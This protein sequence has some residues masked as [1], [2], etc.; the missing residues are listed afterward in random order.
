MAENTFIRPEVHLR[1][2]MIAGL[3]KLELIP[4]ANF[5]EGRII[6]SYYRNGLRLFQNGVCSLFLSS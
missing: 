2:E 3:L 6:F 1:D 5:N 4:W